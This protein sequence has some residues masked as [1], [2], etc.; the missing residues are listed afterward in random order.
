M[1]SVSYSLKAYYQKY[2][3]NVYSSNVYHLVVA[4]PDV[5]A[6][7]ELGPVMLKDV[8]KVQQKLHQTMHVKSLLFFSL[9]YFHLGRPPLDQNKS[10]PANSLFNI[11]RKHYVHVCMYVSR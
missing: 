5:V 6:I 1:L 7:L 10:V 9:Y 11:I 3:C 2:T 4:A 8:T